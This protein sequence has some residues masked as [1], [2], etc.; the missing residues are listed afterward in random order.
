ML[1]FQSP[2][3]EASFASSGTLQSYVGSVIVVGFFCFVLFLFSLVSEVIF[4]EA[5]FRQGSRLRVPLLL[6]HA[7]PQH[8]IGRDQHDTDDE[9]NRKS[10]NQAL[11]H[12][13]LLD[14]LRR[15][16]T[17]GGRGKI[18]LQQGPL[19]Q[20]IYCSTDV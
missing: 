4:L 7:A 16:G 5:A 18:V 8:L 9:S 20:V 11:A 6:F 14:L 2:A 15:A 10:T 17:Y 3:H 13:S 1:S 19:N 12:A